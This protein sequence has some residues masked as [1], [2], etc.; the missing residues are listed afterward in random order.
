MLTEYYETGLNA[1]ITTQGRV[2]GEHMGWGFVGRAPNQLAR[3]TATGDR[4]RS[5]SSETDA[6]WELARASF[7]RAIAR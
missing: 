1:H 5:S 3:A 4:D 7:A 6:T 2:R